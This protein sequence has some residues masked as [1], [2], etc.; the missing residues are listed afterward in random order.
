MKIVVL[1][2]QVPD[3]SL[4][5]HLS[6][7]DF[8]V[9]R[10]SASN[11]ISEIDENAIEA[12]LVLAEETGGE[13]TVLTVGPDHATESVR[14]ALSMGPDKA[15]HVVDDA[16]H[17]SCAVTTSKILAG[18]LGKQ[19]Y[20]IVLCG[21]ESTDG[22][23]QVMAQML[24]QRLGIAALTGA[25]KLTVDGGKITV[26]RQTE[27]GY[28]VVSAAAP[29]IVSV[30]DSMNTPRYPSLK[31]IMA[32]KRKPVETL[33]LSDLDIDPATVGA[34]AATSTVVSAEPRPPRGAGQKITDEGSGGSSLAEFLAS[35]KFV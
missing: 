26:E 32:A 25:R 21:A 35:E 5:R 23:T 2:K 11:V 8:T 9:D 13:V 17:G 30:W 33:S 20:D 6:S 16:I 15:V 10:A 19:E 18:A 31:G 28:Q 24:S 3:S 4:E 27:D 12:A 34:G 14:K 29:A 1:V 22:G 7:D